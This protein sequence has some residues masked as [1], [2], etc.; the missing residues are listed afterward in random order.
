MARLNIIEVWA[1]R[2]KTTESVVGA[3]L[4]ATHVVEPGI[5]GERVDYVGLAVYRS[6]R[7]EM[8]RFSGGYATVNGNK[9][10]FHFYVTDYLGNNPAVVNA[11]GGYE[12]LIRQE[13]S[14]LS[15]QSY[16]Y[17]QSGPYLPS[18]ISD[19]EQNNYAQILKASAKNSLLQDY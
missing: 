3:R 10:D 16:A 18:K 12:N 2:I 5:V 13:H 4:A 1:R 17:T 6:G 9:T 11:D 7:L 8:V 19:F 14:L 15:R